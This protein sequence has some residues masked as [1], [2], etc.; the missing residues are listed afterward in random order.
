MNAP[1]I[2]ADGYVHIC[3]GEFYPCPCCGDAT[4]GDGFSRPPCDD[5]QKAECEPNHD[6]GYDDCQRQCPT[7]GIPC[8]AEFYVFVVWGKDVPGGTET[9]YSDAYV[10]SE[11]MTA[12]VESGDALIPA[13]AYV[14][15]CDVRELDRS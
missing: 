9:D 3:T 10:C 14:I 1:W 4:S 5:C 2:E 6:G 7:C 12:D 15:E 8:L 11:H 13:D